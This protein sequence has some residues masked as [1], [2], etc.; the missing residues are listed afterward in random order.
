MCVVKTLFYLKESADDIYD[1]FFLNLG[2]FEGNG[3]RFVLVRVRPLSLSV[4]SLSSDQKRASP[5][6]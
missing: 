5:L 3:K 4:V 2:M 1:A 6:F